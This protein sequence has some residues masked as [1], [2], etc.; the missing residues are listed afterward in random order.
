MEQTDAALPVTRGADGVSWRSGCVHQSVL[1]YSPPGTRKPAPVCAA[2]VRLALSRP[3][4]HK[5]RYMWFIR[6]KF[7]KN[8][9]TSSGC[10]FPIRVYPQIRIGAFTKSVKRRILYVEKSRKAARSACCP[11][12]HVTRIIRSIA[13]DKLTSSSGRQP[14][15]FFEKAPAPKVYLPILEFVVT[16]ESSWHRIHFVPLQE[17][18]QKSEAGRRKSFSDI[19]L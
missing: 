1:R 14:I 9:L 15:T 18:R 16:S 13:P 12:R 7:W 8:S 19:G 2:P 17:R 11:D 3:S 10:G 6:Q 4:S 5:S